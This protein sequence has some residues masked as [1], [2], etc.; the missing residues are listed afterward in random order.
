MTDRA[1]ERQTP[2]ELARETLDRLRRRIEYR[3]RDWPVAPAGLLGALSR[4]R[5]A[6]ALD[7]GPFDVIWSE[8]DSA[9]AWTCVHGRP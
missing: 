7:R 1:Y 5:D 8:L 6:L 9:W 3:I 2:D 4:A